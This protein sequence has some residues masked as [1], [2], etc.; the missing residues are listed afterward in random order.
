M[1]NNS[2]IDLKIYGKG[3]SS[4]GTFDAVKIAGEGKI[5]GNIICSVFKIH[6]DAKVEGNVKTEYGII[7]GKTVIKGSL[8]ADSFK[9]NG[10][11]EVEGDITVKEIKISGESI[12]GGN[13][14]S[15]KIEIRGRLKVDKDCN[16]EVFSSKGGFVINGLLNAGNIDIEL[17]APCKAKEI[18]GENI[19]VKRGNVFSLR[20][21]INSIFPSFNLND[22][23]T[24]EIIEG[25][26]IYL[27]WTK[28][29]IVRGNN[30]NIGPG[31]QIELVEFKK[32]FQQDKSAKVNNNK[33]I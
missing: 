28:A 31:C 30:I 23:L 11:S 3:S 29:K 32:S 13:I 17:Y 14:S 26:E 33:K 10:S 2:K 22:D 9:I 5:N 1:E 27:E 4:G 15:E 8:E 18:G 19:S 20:S 7:N 25:D 24:T 12:T 21:I 6:G 16:S